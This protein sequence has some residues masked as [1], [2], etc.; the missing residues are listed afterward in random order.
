MPARRKTDPNQ[1]S[2]LLPEGSGRRAV[3]VSS[4]PAEP[5]KGETAP[6]GGDCFAQHFHKTARLAWRI[7]WTSN[8]STM[9]S[10]RQRGKENILR[11]HRM[12]RNAPAAMAAAI[13]DV[14]EG[15]R[16]RWPKG[17]D[18][19]I[20]DHLQA[21]N[22]GSRRCRC[23]PRLATLGAVYDLKE[24]FKSLNK[25]YF[26]NAIEAE[27]GWMTARPLRRRSIKLGSY[28]ESIDRIRIHPALD[29]AEVPR[30]V[31]ESIVF[32]EMVHVKL[33]ARPGV[34][35]ATHGPEFKREMARYPHLDEAERWIHA[36]LDMLLTGRAGKKRSRG[37]R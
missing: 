13:A 31:I 28:S 5:E 2:L 14:V 7:I 32:H 36:N 23:P 1:L 8:A 26:N 3:S 33:K 18:A 24:L 25:T 16:R 17:I 19:Y 15:R 30:L 6:S 35:Y 4:A 12:F 11:I 21:A 10:Y 37:K 34:H 22:E 9:I 20:R 29:R 27:I